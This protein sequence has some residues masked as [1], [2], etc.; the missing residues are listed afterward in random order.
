MK[1]EIT[2]DK[3]NPLLDRREVRFTVDTKT[4]PSRKEIKSTIANSLKAKE[5]LLVI[6]TIRQISGKNLSEGYVKVYANTE[7]LKEIELGYKLERG[8]K[9]QKKPEEPAPAPE[10]KPPEG[11]AP[12][13]EEE[14]PAEEAKEEAKEEK[15][16]EG[17][18]SEE[19]E[20]PKPE[21]AEN[22]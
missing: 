6:D 7:A 8:T 12:A 3:K 4:T 2:E 5:D 18:P 17:A 9:E 13:A 20:K 21:V 15:P 1:I 19:K 14:K 11:E 16:A 10:Q 22:G